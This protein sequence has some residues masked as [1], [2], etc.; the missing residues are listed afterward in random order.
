MGGDYG[1]VPDFPGYRGVRQ[2][3][4][5]VDVRPLGKPFGRRRDRPAKL[6]KKT[7]KNG[8]LVLAEGG[9]L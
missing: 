1:S 3:R 2:E 8:K 4:N 6:R 5:P 7:I 9:S